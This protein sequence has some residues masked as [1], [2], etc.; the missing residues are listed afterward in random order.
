MSNKKENPFKSSKMPLPMKLYFMALNLTFK[1]LALISPK[2]AGKLALQI[3]MIPP[4]AAPPRRENEIR[5]AANLSYRNINN[6]QIAVRIWELESTKENAPTILLSHGWAG[7]TSQFL[8]FID[9]LLAAGYR[10]VG[11]DIT[12]H[13]DSS[14]KSTN[15]IEGTQVLAT[16]AKEFAP[17]DTIIAHSFG[18][19]TTLL[20]L[21]RYDINIPKIVLIGAYSRISFIID[22]FSNIFKLNQSTRNEMT[23]QG[24]NKFRDKYEIKWDW[25]SI[26]PINTIKS[27]EG[28]ILFIHDETDHEVP[29][30]E[31]T[32]LHQSKPDANIITTT[33]LG[34]RRILRDTSVVESV[35]AFIK[36]NK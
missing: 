22:L 24:L 14:G 1:L 5:Q 34:H 36:N 13:G 12:A 8:T 3:F 25:D 28:N 30:A 35:L 18:T 23:Q 19:G 33:G 11:A 21:D 6:Q 15:I 4:N 29:I 2:L 10:V 32:K 7:R 9:A 31:A 27:Y 26:T 20:A 16:I 17:I